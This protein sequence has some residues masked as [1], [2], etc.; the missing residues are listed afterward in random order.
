MVALK[1]VQP[2]SVSR[3]IY[4]RGYWRWNK[5][6]NQLEAPQISSG[7]AEA[8]STLGKDRSEASPEQTYETEKGM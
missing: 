3:L 6:A 5:I 8:G 1:L 2:V 4:H 7:V